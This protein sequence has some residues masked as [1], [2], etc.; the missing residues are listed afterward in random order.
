MTFNINF[1]AV[2]VDM[3]QIKD[4]STEHKQQI[5]NVHSRTCTGYPITESKF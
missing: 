3:L 1:E 2:Q 5:N 4:L